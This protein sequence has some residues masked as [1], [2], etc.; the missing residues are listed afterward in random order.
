[1]KKRLKKTKAKAK[2]GKLQKRT[3]GKKIV[4]RRNVKSSVSKLSN[5]LAALS[6]ATHLRIENVKIVAPEKGER[7]LALK[8]LQ[9]IYE[10]S[11]LSGDETQVFRS[12]LERYESRSMDKEELYSFLSENPSI[13]RKI[14]ENI[15][16][17][18]E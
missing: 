7:D 14:W 5:E 16:F 1:M 10:N 2:K 11:A 6:S 18:E 4:A 17:G 15:T 8:T 12:F 9:M 13:R 3:S